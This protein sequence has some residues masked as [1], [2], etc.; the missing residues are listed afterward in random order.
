MAYACGWAGELVQLS[1]QQIIDCDT[2]SNGCKSGSIENVFNYA[3]TNSIMKEEDYPYKGEMKIF[4]PSCK[5]DASKGVTTIS[6][7][8]MIQTNDGDCIKG[9]LE[10][11]PLT[12]GVASSSWH[13]KLYKFGAIDSLDCGTDLDHMLL[14]TGYGSYDGTVEYIELKNSWGTH[15]GIDGY[16]KIK[17]KYGEPGICG[18]NKMP[19]QPI[20]N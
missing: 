19:I 17:V 9:A 2:A 11:A 4:S 15:W 5:Y 6:D 8:K 18:I 12:V 13:F 1:E 3:K 14:A 16:V 10:D 20:I 7:F